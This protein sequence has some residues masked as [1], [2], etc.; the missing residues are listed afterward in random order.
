MASDEDTPNVRQGSPPVAAADAAVEDSI[1]M[2]DPSGVITSCNEAAQR[3]LGCRAE[4]AVGRS[5]LTFHDPV[6]IV[7]RATVL[8]VEPGIDVLT[9]AA[10][11]D[12]A[13][14]REWTCVG[15]GG[16]RVP[17]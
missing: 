1:V 12:P 3:L 14:G 10:W 5:L 7:Y 2:I 9:A 13:M 4:D 6:D 8:D 17:V 16:E 11:P 15:A